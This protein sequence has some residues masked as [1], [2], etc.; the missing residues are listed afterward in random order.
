MTYR[1]IQYV[2]DSVGIAYLTLNRPEAKN[3]MTGE[4]YDEA[5]A[6]VADIEAS[7]AVRAVV[8]SGNGDVFCSGGDFRYQR[9]QA[10]R[11]QHERIAEA[12]KLALWLRELDTLSKPVIGR[13]AGHAY[14]GGVGLVAICDVV[15]ATESARFCLSEVGLGLLPSMISPYVVRKLG[16]SNSRR[17]FL[18]AAPFSA[19]EAM[20]M[21]L[22]H[23][24]VAA[25][26]MDQ[27][28]EWHLDKYL[29]CAPG[30]IAATKKLVDF[31]DRHQFEE[32][33]AYTVDRVAEMWAWDEAAEGISS[34]LEKRA[35]AWVVRREDGKPK[36]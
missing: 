11:P 36:H 34:F 33:F 4:M 1:T 13:I 2:V 6:V 25:E 18:N 28:I 9:S 35:P 10:S 30:A 3:A 32:N 7:R 5:R 15:I 19:R 12:S 21:G 20:G 27:A 22:V 16:I 17:V 29:R 24:V 26:S 14:G 31:V 23:Q 8:L